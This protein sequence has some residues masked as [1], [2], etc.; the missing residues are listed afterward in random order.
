MKKTN[1]VLIIALVATIAVA[2]FIT[3]S[4]GKHKKYSQRAFWKDATVADVHAMPDVVFR[5][6]NHNGPV[7]MW[8]ATTT[9]NPEVISALVDRGADINEADAVAKGT[10]LSAAAGYNQ[11]PEII[12]RLVQR[13][14]EIDKVVG[15][16]NK[17]P[18][19]IAA[20][21]NPNPLIVEALIKNGASLTYQDKMGLTA[22]RS[23]KLMGS[24]TVVEV[25]ERYSK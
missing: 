3:L 11:N 8:A 9:P 5:R 25:L 2:I 24:P 4:G 16:N 17:T 7:L 12:D 10:P 21:I 22:L 14:A 13:G 20:E 1:P 18:L 6:G 23:A 19:I 15:S